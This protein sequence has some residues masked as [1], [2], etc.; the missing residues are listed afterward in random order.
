[1][2]GN[3]DEMVRAARNQS[4][5]RSI[6]EKIKPLNEAFS[7]TDADPEWICECDDQACVQPMPMT[8]SEYE[9]LRSQP[10][11]F[12]VL[13]GHV[14]AKVE[15]VVHETDNYVVVEKLGAGAQVAIEKDPRSTE[16]GQPS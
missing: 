16:I 8:F 5:Y 11:R 6:N 1:V 12:A 14:N 9:A 4:L 15:R 3:A 7:L 10:N 2:S 13:H